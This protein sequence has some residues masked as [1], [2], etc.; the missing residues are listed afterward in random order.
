M[1]LFA[2][3]KPL[4]PNTRTMVTII[5]FVM[6]I[7]LWCAVSYLPFVWHPQTEITDPGSVSYF[8]EDMLV[9]NEVFE[10]EFLK[11]QEAGKALPA[12]DPAN[13]VYLPAPHEVAT[14]FYTAFTTEPKRRSEMW[15]H[16]SLWSSIQVIFWGFVLSSIIG[17]PLG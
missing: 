12:G 13:P 9:D 17:I 4:P 1:S 2:V 16:E 11:A 7:L 10:K 8:K 3:N 14:A 15:L 6:P 5:S